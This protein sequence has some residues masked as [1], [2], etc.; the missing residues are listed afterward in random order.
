MLDA[1]AVFDHCHHLHAEK[2]SLNVACFQ[3]TWRI[4]HYLTAQSERPVDHEKL[5]HVATCC[6]V[7]ARDGQGTREIDGIKTQVLAT[8]RHM[9]MHDK[10]WQGMTRHGKA[11]QGMRRRK[12]PFL[13]PSFRYFQAKLLETSETYLKHLEVS[14][15]NRWSNILPAK[16]K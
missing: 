3:C 9:T 16:R 13:C 5:Q 12:V 6:R 15:V 11:W 14:P 4:W 7:Y 8:Q 10:A 2:Q 1:P